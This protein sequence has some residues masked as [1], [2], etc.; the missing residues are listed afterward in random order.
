MCQALGQ[1]SVRAMSKLD[2]YLIERK[3][4]KELITYPGEVQ[5]IHGRL[6]Y[7]GQSSAVV[8]TVPE[9][10]RKD[11]LVLIMGPASVQELDQYYGGH[12]IV[13]LCCQTKANC[14]DA[15]RRKA[16]L[17]NLD[18][19][20]KEVNQLFGASDDPDTA[21][22]ILLCPYNTAVRRLSTKAD[23]IV[24]NLYN[25]NSMKDAIES[26]SKPADPIREA[27]AEEVQDADLDFDRSR[28]PRTFVA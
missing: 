13:W 22:T 19:V 27:D 11:K 1:H 25:G 28:R 5:R 18:Q 10:H 9:N 12:F 3:S 15:N 16:T 24:G 23:D 17:D 2:L 7:I 21:R 8:L 26:A 6:V 4:I 14:T 20:Q